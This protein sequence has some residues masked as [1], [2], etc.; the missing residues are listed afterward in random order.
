MHY[1]THPSARLNCQIRFLWV[2]VCFIYFVFCLFLFLPADSHSGERR[3]SNIQPQPGRQHHQI[4]RYHLS[5]SQGTNTRT[6][7]SAAARPPG[8]EKRLCLS[9]DCQMRAFTV[10][11]ITTAHI[12][13]ARSVFL[14][15]L[16]LSS[17]HSSVRFPC[18]HSSS[19]LLSV[20]VYLFLCLALLCPLVSPPQPPPTIKLL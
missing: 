15:C 16:F 2:W 9:R 7:R 17:C 10:E 19:L 11:R 18:A 6:H 4:P 20:S 13:P 3:G 1:V 12:Y 5:H 14:F 8:R